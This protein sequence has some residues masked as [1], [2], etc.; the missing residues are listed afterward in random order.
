MSSKLIPPTESIHVGVL[1][2]SGLA[3]VA[4]CACLMYVVA[5]FLERRDRLWQA[6]DQH[7]DV[8]YALRSMF[9]QK[10]GIDIRRARRRRGSLVPEL[11]VPLKADVECKGERA[12]LGSGCPRG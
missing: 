5:K 6:I 8:L 4:P 12:A 3:D 10:V 1:P 9:V 11:R 7:A 2:R